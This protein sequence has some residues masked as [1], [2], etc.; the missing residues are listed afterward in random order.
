M[1]LVCLFR[2]LEN[3]LECERMEEVSLTSIELGLEFNPV[4]SEEK[5]K[6]K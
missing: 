6:I 5:E 3:G 2:L 1:D 4:Q